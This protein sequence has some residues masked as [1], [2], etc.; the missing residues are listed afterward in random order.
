MA[1]SCIELYLTNNVLWKIQDLG[2]TKWARLSKFYDHKTLSNK[3]FL[4]NR[5]F[6]FKIDQNKTLD[7]NI[8]QFK[9][10]N[11]QFANMDKKVDKEDQAIILLNALQ[12]SYNELK[13]AIKYGREDLKLDF[14]RRRIIGA[15]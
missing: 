1:Y 9:M 5:L 3:I 12:E 6:G 10:I 4:K 7:Y 11:A 2:I 8:D 15:F 14:D 13:T